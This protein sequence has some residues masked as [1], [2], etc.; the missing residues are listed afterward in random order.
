MPWKSL[1]VTE[2]KC[3]FI[4]EWK[5]GALSFLALCCK[6]LISRKT[7]YK[8][9][10]RYRRHG[11]I[12]LRDRPRRPRRLARRKSAHWS[13]R[14][15]Q[16]RRRYPHWGPKK[17]FCKL[18]ERYGRRG[19]PAVSTLRDWLRQWGWSQRR[20]RRS[21]RGPRL[22]RSALTQP[23]RPNEVWTVDFKGW[24]RTGDGQRCE[25][26]TVRDLKSRYL[27]ALSLLA[28]QSERRARPAFA[29]LFAARGLPDLIRVDNGGPFG[30][31]GAAGLS[32]LSAWWVRLGIGVEFIRPGHPQDNGGHE[33][34][35]RDYKAETAHPPAARW[36]GQLGRT[37]RF[38]RR[39]NEE[40]PHEAL[41]GRT[42]AAV[43]RASRRKYSRRVAELVYPEAWAVRRVR[44]N[45][46]LK[47]EGRRRFV[48]E[49]FV[50]QRVG[51]KPVGVGQHEVYF[52][53][54]LL[55]TL[56]AR[57]RGGVRPATYRRAPAS[58]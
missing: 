19:T 46:A 51:L 57:D 33:R 29:R 12:G 4:L 15:R 26:L 2:A 14:V 7:G 53:H 56:H 13:R 38:V 48:G 42:P 43:Y 9:R 47:W 40:R 21:P 45:G 3:K 28:D 36:S 55:G 24:F 27:L 35:H 44:S 50:G 25:P 31:T 32:R 18:V 11:W 10:R 58:C 22:V 23:R 39:Y 16:L 6:P 52:A 49:A 20:R 17:L 37:R 41:G 30:S 1:S 34:M 5:Q 54:L 8:W